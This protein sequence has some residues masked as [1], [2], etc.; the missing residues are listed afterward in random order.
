MATIDVGILGKVLIVDDIP[1]N[2][3]VLSELLQDMGYQVYASPN[4][5][6]ALKQLQTIRPDLILLDIV[7]PDMNGYQ[8]CEAIKET[9]E[10]KDI[11]IIFISALSETQD[12]INAFKAGGVDY[13]NKP[14]QKEEVLARVSTHIALSRTQ[15]KLQASHDDL[16]TK[17]EKRTAELATKE[18]QLKRALE[19]T[20]DAVATTLEKRDP[21]TAG[22]QRN[23]ALLSVAIGKEMGLDEEQINAIRLGASI[24]DIGKIHVPAEILNTP[25]RLSEIE[26]ELIKTH[27]QQGYEILK[28]VDFPWPIQDVILQ[29]HERLDGSGYP[30]GL[31]GNEICLESRIVAVA[32][33]VE[34]ICNHR[35]YRS[36]LGIDDALKV[37][38]QGR[39]LLFDEDAVD[40]CLSLFQE[41]GFR[42]EFDMD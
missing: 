7:M 12:K 18:R 11:P 30:Y 2:L 40:A 27:P 41:K 42:F 9:E 20:I 4:G 10:I 37:I 32:D 29:H 35:P 17:V 5:E 31:K 38:K 13:I 34:A 24:H 6:F 3:S 21:Y 22:H 36:A 1:E 25:R 14:F 23:V 15:K 28:D 19:Q 33:V 26:F 39:K 8:V 16:E